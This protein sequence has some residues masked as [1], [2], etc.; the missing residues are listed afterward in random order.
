MMVQ[1]VTDHGAIN[2]R[3][4]NRKSSLCELA[5]QLIGEKNLEILTLRCQS[6]TRT[7]GFSFLF[8]TADYV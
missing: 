8:K 4:K 5:V 6:N 1:T 7:K 2:G 3:K